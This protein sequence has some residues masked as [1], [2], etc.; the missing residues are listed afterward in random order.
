MLLIFDE[1]FLPNYRSM[2]RTKIFASQF[3]Y[4]GLLNSNTKCA[5]LY[6]YT[7]YTYMERKE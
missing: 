2:K 1:D 3:Y 6:S 4:P 5:S 7:L